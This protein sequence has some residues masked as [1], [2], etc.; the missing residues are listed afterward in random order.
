MSRVRVV[1]FSDDEPSR[2]SAELDSEG[3]QKINLDAQDV[4]RTENQRYAVDVT[5]M[6]PST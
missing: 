1:R 4:K 5:K 6:I 2:E 3:K